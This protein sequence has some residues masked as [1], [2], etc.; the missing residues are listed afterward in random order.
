MLG[1]AAHLNSRGVQRGKNH[2][3]ANH[4]TPQPG[5]GRNQ[6]G[7]MAARFHL[8]DMQ[9]TR[10]GFER[11]AVF[12]HIFHRHKFVEN[13]VV[14][15]KQHILFFG[16]FERSVLYAEKA[17]GGVVG[18][19]KVKIVFP[20][21]VDKRFAVGRKTDPAVEKYFQIG[22]HFGYGV[23]AAHIQEPFKQHHR[24]RRHARNLGDMGVQHRFAHALQLAFPFVHKR[25]V[26][27]GGA[28]HLSPKGQMF[29][30]NG[31]HIAL[32]NIGIGRGVQT[33]AHGKVLAVENLAVGMVAQVE[34]K[35]IH[36][37]FVV[38]LVK[39][40]TAY[41]NK[42]AFVGRGAARLGKP[43][44]QARPQH[45]AFAAPHKVEIGFKPIVRH[46]RHALLIEVMQGFEVG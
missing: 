43:L 15:H 35:H 38:A 17:F 18:F 14:E 26:E 13:A 9:T 34:G 40:L 21:E 28:A 41:G 10:P 16:G 1:A 36:A 25:N 3:V 20:D 23:F 4:I 19:H 46:L 45:I 37:A 33:A 39:G 29:H 30:D 22:P 12:V 11:E 8:P 32:Q 6:N 24:P 31:R 2:R 7:V 27:L 42:L 44:H 5:V